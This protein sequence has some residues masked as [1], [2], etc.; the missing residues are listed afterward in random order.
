MSSLSVHFILKTFNRFE[1]YFCGS[2]FTAFAE[3]SHALGAAVLQVLERV[4]L[5]HRLLNFSVQASSHGSV[6]VFMCFVEALNVLGKMQIESI[7]N[8][9]Q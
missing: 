3:I 6:G 5:Y 1:S 4:V 9:L 8:N 2:V 7:L